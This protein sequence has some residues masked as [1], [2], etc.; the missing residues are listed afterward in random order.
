MLVFWLEVSVIIL[1]TVP[2]AYKCGLVFTQESDAKGKPFM[3]KH[4]ELHTD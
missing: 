2:P 1:S 3:F 4:D